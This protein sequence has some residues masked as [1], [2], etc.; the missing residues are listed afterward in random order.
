MK[1]LLLP[2][3]AAAMLT[4][5][6]PTDGPKPSPRTEPIPYQLDAR[7]VQVL[8]RPQRIDFGRTDHSAERA[9]TKLVGQAAVSRAICGDGS[10]FVAWADGTRLHF[11]G[12]AFRGW[13]K[14]GADGVLQKGGTTCG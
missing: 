11:R 2:I 12:G 14:T 4:G 8:G 6:A 13:S 1:N 9:M 10:P 7:G 3:L 5:C